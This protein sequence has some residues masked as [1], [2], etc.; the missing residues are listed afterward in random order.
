MDGGGSTIAA[1]WQRAEYATLLVLVAVSVAP[2]AIGIAWFDYPW[3]WTGEE[4]GASYVPGALDFVVART[5]S[6]SRVPGPLLRGMVVTLGVSL[7]A[8]LLALP[9]GIALGVAATAHNRGLVLYARGYVEAVRN[10][11]LLIQ[12]FIVYYIVGKV[13]DIL[14]WGAL[15]SDYRAAAL[16]TLALAVFSSAYLAEIVRG[17]IAALPHGQSE[18]ARALGLSSLQA[19]RYVILP[20]ALRATLPAMAGQ[21]VNLVKDSSLLSVIGVLELTK[22]TREAFGSSFLAL[23]LWMLAALLYLAI[24]LPLSQ[25]VRW[26]ELRLRRGERG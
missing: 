18:A 9:A 12:I 8:L 22:R 13:A 7:A 17:G 23:E 15:W 21:F 16:G 24:T 6:G 2:L 5:P 14:P 11:P 1:R 4:R 20:Q 25:A 10:S 26:L 19:L 3:R